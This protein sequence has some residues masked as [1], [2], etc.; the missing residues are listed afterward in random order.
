MDLMMIG[1]RIADI[2]NML[3]D[4][5][6]K[7]GK[8]AKIVVYSQENCKAILS[9]IEKELKTHPSEEQKNAAVLQMPFMEEQSHDNSAGAE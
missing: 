6:I 8:N 1:N 4:L 9:E 7:G 3:N 2:H 5:E